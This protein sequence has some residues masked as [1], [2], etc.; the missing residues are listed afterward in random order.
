MYLDNLRDSITRV[1]DKDK[2]LEY[3]KK[4]SSEQ[5]LLRHRSTLLIRDPETNKL[6]AANSREDRNFNDVSPFYFPGGGLYDDE[7]DT[8]RTPTEEEILE[9]AR[10]EALEE[11]GMT[12]KNPR[13]IGGLANVIKQKAW[14]DR[15]LSKRGVPYEGG[16]EHLVLADKGD[17]DNSLYNVEGDAF[18]KGQYYDPQEVY[19]SLYEYG[20]QGGQ[21]SPYNVEQARAIK[22][23]LLSKQANLVGRAVKGVAK[24]VR[25]VGNQAKQFKQNQI[26]DLKNI[27]I[28]EKTVKFPSG[29]SHTFTRTL[30]DN[31]EINKFR[32]YMQRRHGA[33]PKKPLNESIGT[34]LLNNPQYRGDVAIHY[35]AKPQV[36]TAL[37]V[38]QQGSQLIDDLAK[39]SQYP[40]S[41]EQARVIKDNLLKKKLVTS[42]Y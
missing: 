6:L 42:A 3:F 30:K 8:P 39:F 25:N 5:P 16:H 23:H 32:N 7:Y 36:Q 37:N 18:T 1:D 20:Q 33:R 17:I 38:A 35:A 15:A 28:S 31:S 34:E 19:D 2:F 11:L 22:E 12:L 10:R 14:R 4:T 40:A 21:F 27:P 41:K 29:N 9:G 24:G 13:I 26:K